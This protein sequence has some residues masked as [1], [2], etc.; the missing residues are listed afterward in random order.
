MQFVTYPNC[1][2]EKKAV[3]SYLYRGFRAVIANAKSVV[4]IDKRND[5]R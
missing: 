3:C 5:I 1:L 2:A 4:P